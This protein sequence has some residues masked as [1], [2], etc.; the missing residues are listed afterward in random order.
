MLRALLIDDEKNAL[1]ALRKLLEQF[2]PEVHVI[3]EAQTAL[4]GLR[5]IRQQNPDIV[6]LD[7]EMPGGTGF[8]L[9]E[10][11]DKK[12]FSVIFTTAHEQYTIP[13]IRAGASDYLLKPVS[14]EELRAAIHRVSGKGKAGLATTE[15]FRVSVS[16]NK[17]TW[18]VPVTDIIY[19]EAEGRYSR[20]FLTGGVEYP[21]SKNLGELQSEL[22]HMKFFRVHKSWLVNCRHVMRIASSDGGFAILSNGKEIEISRRRR[23]D[24]MRMMEPGVC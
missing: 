16:N 20:F 19:I 4:D 23:A 3:G 8:D 6:F 1:S 18:F 7:V 24:F 14:L 9:L 2:C 5:L 21:V 13:A 12:N 11:L 17:G 15:D 10:A 22:A